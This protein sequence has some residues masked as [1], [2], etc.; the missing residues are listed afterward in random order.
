MRKENV[1]AAHWGR[2]WSS[3]TT[4]RRARNRV[5]AAKRCSTWHLYSYL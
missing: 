4:E 5:T 2:T 3:R 1:A